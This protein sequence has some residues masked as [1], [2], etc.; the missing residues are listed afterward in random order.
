MKR[1][2]YLLCVVIF[3]QITT[4]ACSQKKPTNLNEFKIELSEFIEK[5]IKKSEVVGL[6][7]AL[8][9]NQEI[10]WADGFGFADKANNV[11]ATSQTVYRIASISK[12]FTAT[13]VMQLQENGKLN[14]DNPIQS[15]IPE[16]NIKSRFEKPGV[17]TTR[18]ILTHHSGLPNDIFYQAFTEHPDPISSTVDLLNKEYTCTQPNTIYSYSNVGFDLLGAL[19][20]RT[21]GE[22]FYDYASSHLFQPMDMKSSSFKLTPEMEV[23]YSKGYVKDKEF[24]EPLSLGIASGMMHSNVMDMANFIKM[25]FNNGNF[26][27]KQI[28]KAETLKEMQSKQ[29]TGC[30]L[31]FNYSIGLGWDINQKSDLSYAGG[32]AGHGGD[33]YVYHGSL[34][35]FTDHKIGVIVLDNS[36]SGASVCRTIANK[37][38]MRYLD[39]KLGIKPIKVDDIKIETAAI[40]DSQLSTISGDYTMG[41]ECLTFKTKKGKLETEQ[42][43]TRLVF[44]PNKAGSFTVKAMLMG[45]IPF[46]VDNQF[47]AFKKFDNVD[48]LLFI[49][50]ARDTSVAG[51]RISKSEITNAW[52]NRLGKYEIVNDDTPFRIITDFVIREKDRYLFLDAK[53]LGEEASILIRP[54]SDNEAIVEGIGRNTGATVSFN[55]DELYYAGLKMKKKME[56]VKKK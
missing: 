12:L 2:S 25:T 39:F 22:N 40:S 4:T 51:F 29:N 7:F 5:S 52:R 41:L 26:N 9:D 35:T 11:K 36:E 6:S 16:F 48:Y 8:V 13:A 20:E 37:I 24:N 43:S 55:G 1:T 33:T 53:I 34:K 31:D 3:V 54:I 14:I 50:N 44:T 27:G 17:I 42:N 30:K 10:I 21:S 46:K 15:Y 47:F 28:I 49:E 45:F 18:S 19:V 23:Y 32:Y 38:L 56:E